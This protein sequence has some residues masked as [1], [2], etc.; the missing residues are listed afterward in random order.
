MAISINDWDTSNNRD[1]EGSRLRSRYEQPGFQRDAN[2]DD[3][4]DPNDT[5]PQ[6]PAK[7]A[8]EDAQV[9]NLF[10]QAL[11]QGTEYQQQ[12]LKHWKRSYQAWN[13][14]HHD[15]SKYRTQR[16]RG[17]TRLYRPKTRATVRKKQAEAAAALFSTPDAIVTGP[18]NPADKR[19]EAS[20]A[21]TKELVNFRLDRSNEN[22]GIPWF[23]ISMGAHLSAQ[24]TGICASKQYWE[25]KAVE[26]GEFEQ[27]PITVDGM[28]DEMG[29]PIVF[30][31]MDD[32]SR[33]IMKVVRDRP[34]I[35]LLEPEQIIRDPAADWSDQAQDSS[36]LILKFPMTVADAK[37]F[38]KSQS[39]TSRVKFRTTITDEQIEGAAGRDTQAGTEADQIQRARSQDGTTRYGDASIDRSFQI[40]WLH[41]TF[42]KFDG[43]DYVYWTLGD[44]LLISDLVPTAEAYPEQGGAR[45]V[46]IGVAT[47]E[48]FKIDPMSPVES[49]QPLQQ[50]INDIV[51]LRL[52]ATKQTIAPLAMVKKG[53]GV[54]VKAIQSRTPDTVVY[55]QD[56]GDVK[57]DRPGDVGQSAYMEMEKL[58]AD[59][60]DLAGNFSLGSVQTNRQLG[61]TVGGMQMMTSNANAMGE[62]DLRVWIETWVEPVL[63]QLVKLEQYYE[64]DE[65]VLAIAAD[66][67]QLLEKFGQ[68]RVTDDL[69]NQ[70]VTLTCNVGLGAAD[71]MMSL[72]KFSMAAQ[73]VGQIMAGPLGAAA[74]TDAII[75]EIF[76][77]AGF[78]NASERFF[79]LENA[80]PRTAQIEAAMQE[81]QA[82]LEQL[83]QQLQAAQMQLKDRTDQIASAE[84]IA[85]LN[86]LA[87]LIKQKLTITGNLA[88]TEMDHQHQADQAQ[89]QQEFQTDQQFNQLAGEMGKAEHAHAMGMEKDEASRAFQAEQSDQ[90]RAFQAEQGA[91]QPAPGGAAP[92]P[93]PQPQQEPT[94]DMAAMLGIR[95]P[96]MAPLIQT[97]LQGLQMIAAQ[98]QQGQQQTA[99]LIARSSQ[100]QTQAIMQGNRQV[101]QAIT[102]P[103]RIIRDQNGQMAGAVSQLPQAGA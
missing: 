18:A 94:D 99:Q 60:D 88:K 47:L 20:A 64:S 92:Q 39:A 89:M 36:Y 35:R 51:N 3:T 71:P 28:V 68:D 58:N 53:R 1:A 32:E 33:P 56:D 6:T 80:D 87:G 101:V 13:N 31:Y 12:M 97:M 95:Q 67:A 41:E 65:V 103:K 17:R 50:E 29:Q 46:T 96:D 44:K 69:L 100:Q 9:M 98:I 16:Y 27:A 85:K 75:D 54:D 7:P 45:P 26:S 15:D 93:K 81:M 19:Q 61:E 63:R 10:A 90:D 23:M 38:I 8:Y 2:V 55:V 66:K 37:V 84:K 22:S 77:K 59:Y 21:V 40:V 4:A 11:R 25:Y 73:N 24:I 30:G 57:F 79:D 34:R 62:F 82:N 102:A 74:K 49:W 76:G 86:A 70:Q 42:M 91:M 48:P 78:K 72:N 52:D 83:T 43:E 5:L 14:E